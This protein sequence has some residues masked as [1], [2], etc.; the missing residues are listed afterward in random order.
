ML[1][2]VEEGSV[3]NILLWM[4]LVRIILGEWISSLRVF[5]LFVSISMQKMGQRFE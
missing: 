1:G 3:V 4:L 5:M 2:D